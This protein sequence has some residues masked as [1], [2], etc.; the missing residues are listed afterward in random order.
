MK[1][2]VDYGGGYKT[3]VKVKTAKGAAEAWTKGRS[4]FW[5]RKKGQL[6]PNPYRFDSWSDRDKKLMRRVLPIFKKYLP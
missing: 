4:Y 6:L 3:S 5:W 1:L 2:T